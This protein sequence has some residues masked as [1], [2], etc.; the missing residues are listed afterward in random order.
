MNQAEVDCL[1]ANTYIELALHAD[2]KSRRRHYAAKGEV[3]SLRARQNRNQG[4]VRSVFDEIRLAKVRL[5]QREPAES[6]WVG[7]HDIRLAAD[8]RS[9]P[10]VNWLAR[11]LPRPDR[12]ILRRARGRPLPRPGTRLRPQGRPR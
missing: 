10:L 1:A 2:N 4:Y 3:H 8:T 12:Q 9:S 11:V 5:A 7:M 6:A